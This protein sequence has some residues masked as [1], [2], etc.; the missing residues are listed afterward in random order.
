MFCVERY[1]VINFSK[2]SLQW[3]VYASEPMNQL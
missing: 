1:I 3:T 2:Y